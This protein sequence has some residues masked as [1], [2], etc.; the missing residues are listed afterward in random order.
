MFFL[1]AASVLE[2]LP[3]QR[4]EAG[5]GCKDVVEVVGDSSGQDTDGFELL[6]LAKLR[7]ELLILLLGSELSAASLDFAEFALNDRG[8][9][10]EIE[11][12]DVVVDAGLEGID[13]AFL[14]DR[15]RDDE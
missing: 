1:G 2:V 11:L 9:T 10:V 8:Q 6:D 3:C 13:G 4:S 7:F 12:R 5:D 15:S 14:A